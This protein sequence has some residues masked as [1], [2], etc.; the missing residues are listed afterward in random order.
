[1]ATASGGTATPLIGP[2]EWSVDLS[3][4]TV[5]TTKGGATNKTFVQGLPNGTIT[6]SGMWDDSETKLVAGVSSTTGVKIYAYP[7]Y[8]NAPGKSISG[9]YWLSVSY[10]ASVSDAVKFTATAVPNAAYTNAL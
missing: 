6:F 9:I 8:A 10:S 2:A 5:E 3:V 1:M 4:D 7:D